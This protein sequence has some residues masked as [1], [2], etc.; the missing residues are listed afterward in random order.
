MCEGRSHKRQLCPVPDVRDES[1][2]GL[3]QAVRPLFLRIVA[4]RFQRNRLHQRPLS[5]HCITSAVELPRLK[6]EVHL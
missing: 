6:A 2:Q 4:Q 5:N 1:L 3:P